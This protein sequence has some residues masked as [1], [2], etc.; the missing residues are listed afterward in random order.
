M[1]QTAKLYRASGDVAHGGIRCSCCTKGCPSTTK[2]LINRRFRR[3]ARR[4]IREEG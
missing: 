2:R 3:T 1:T 4:V